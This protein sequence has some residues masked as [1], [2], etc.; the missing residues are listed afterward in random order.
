M[1]DGV[2]VG[3]G[4]EEKGVSSVTGG[5]APMKEPPTT[6]TPPPFSVF[7]HGASGAHPPSIGTVPNVL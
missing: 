7:K 5:T 6:H 1:K 3:V 2:G 4:G